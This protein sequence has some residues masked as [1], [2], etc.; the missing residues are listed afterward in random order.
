[1]C[2]YYTI[3]IQNRLQAVSLIY[4][5]PTTGTTYL[6]QIF[7]SLYLMNTKAFHFISRVFVLKAPFQ[8]L[9]TLH[10][11]SQGEL[12]CVTSGCSKA[13]DPLPTQRTAKRRHLQQRSTIR[14]SARCLFRVSDKTG[15]I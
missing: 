13:A 6:F 14:L 4:N 7:F 11:P 9:Y 10:F 1:M 8:I 5:I 12:T 3:T 15:H 2:C